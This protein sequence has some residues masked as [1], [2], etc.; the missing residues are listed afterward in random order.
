[1]YILYWWFT[2][3]LFKTTCVSN[4]QI[5]VINKFPFFCTLLNWKEGEKIKKTLKRL[6]E[7]K[8][9]TFLWLRICK[10]WS[11][12]EHKHVLMTFSHRLSIFHFFYSLRSMWKSQ[13]KLQYQQLEYTCDRCDKRKLYA[14]VQKKQKTE[15]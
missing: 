13:N 8:P 10:M 9:T 2:V 12:S 3:S 11:D 5:I 6:I 7:W 4:F 15:Y 1:M 14:T